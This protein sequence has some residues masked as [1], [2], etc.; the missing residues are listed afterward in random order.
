MPALGGVERRDAHQPMHTAFAG[1]HS[2]NSF[3]RD[4][5]GSR[6]D[7]GFF[8]ILIIV[9]LGLEALLLGPAQIHAH[10]HLGPV[11]AFGAARAGVDG[12]DGVHAIGLAGEHG[13]RFQFLGKGS[14]RLDGAFQIREHIFALAGQLEVG[15]D[16]ATAMDQRIIVG[17]QGF[18]TLLVAHQ[19][20][21]SV[22]VVPQRRV[23]EFVFYGG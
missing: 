13:A 22:R 15:F 9:D 3:S 21:A 12:D 2:K 18:Q 5:K 14:Q 8:A 23:G 10:E 4:G 1:Q 16:I 19:W 6:F 17:D 7:A 11:L 20:L